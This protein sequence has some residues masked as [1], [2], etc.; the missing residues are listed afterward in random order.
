MPGLRGLFIPGPTNVPERVRRAMDIPME[1][2]RA[3]DLPQFTLP[4]LED[5]KKVFKCKTGQAFLFPASGT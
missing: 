4:L 1:D 5:V 3:P 2:Q